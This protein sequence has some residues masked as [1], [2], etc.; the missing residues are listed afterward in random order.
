M[1]R[2][3]TLAA[4]ASTVAAA[5]MLYGVKDDARKLRS[6]LQDQERVIRQYENDIAILKAERA[7]LA[8][9]QRI[10]ELA[11]AQ[12]LGPTRAAQYGSLRSIPLRGKTR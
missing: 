12:G 8:R 2:F 9:P 5:F 1:L 3:F 11:R 6:Q 4:M 7:H 10:D